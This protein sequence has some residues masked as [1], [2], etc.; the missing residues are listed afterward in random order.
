MRIVAITVFM[1][2]LAVA[3]LSNA[4][5]DPTPVPDRDWKFNI[6]IINSF[7]CPYA[8]EIRGLDY[9][10]G[11]TAISFSSDPDNKVYTCDAN[12]GTYVGELAMGFSN[13][14]P[15]GICYDADDNVHVNE[16]NGSDIYW[17][18]GAVWSDYGNPSSNKGSGMDFDGTY[19]WETYWTDGVYRFFPDGSGAEF[20][21]MPEVGAQ[22]SGLTVFPYNGNLWLMNASHGEYVFNFYEFDGSVLTYIATVDCPLTPSQSYGLT[23]AAERGTFFWSYSIGSDDWIA[24]LDI[25]L[26]WDEG[27]GGDDTAVVPASIGMI[28]ATY[29]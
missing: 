18:N 13:P 21:D 27:G 10:D 4:T 29:R 26:E 7:Q 12:D 14:H 11:A 25:G 20:Y 15:F 17:Y 2:V 28:K 23:F 9:V 8:G 16:F 1:L 22:L 5:D 6:T 19:V 24:E 3:V